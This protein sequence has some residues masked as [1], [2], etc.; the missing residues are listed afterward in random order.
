MQIFLYFELFFFF[1]HISL[2]PLSFILFS[3]VSGQLWSLHANIIIDCLSLQAGGEGFVERGFRLVIWLRNLRALCCIVFGA[4]HPLAT[5][6]GQEQGARSEGPECRTHETENRQRTWHAFMSR[7]MCNTNT[8]TTSTT[9]PS[10]CV[11]ATILI[12]DIPQFYDF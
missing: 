7:H 12:G 6:P 2:C 1:C 8:T 3:A 11:C 10:V 5:H 9:T 4:P